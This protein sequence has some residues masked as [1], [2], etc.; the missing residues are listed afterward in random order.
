MQTYESVEKMI[1]RINARPMT[2]QQIGQVELSALKMK[3][4]CDA[5]ETLHHHEDQIVEA[6][7]NAAKDAGVPLDEEQIDLLRQ[8]SLL[9]LRHTVMAVATDDDSVLQTFAQEIQTPLMESGIPGSLVRVAMHTLNEEIFEC[10]GDVIGYQLSHMFGPFAN[11]FTTSAVVAEIEVVVANEAVSQVGHPKETSY[12]AEELVE[13]AIRY[14]RASITMLLP[15]GK[16][17]GFSLLAREHNWIERNQPDANYIL[18]LTNALLKATRSKQ[19]LEILPNYLKELTSVLDIIAYSADLQANKK[20]LLKGVKD[21]VDAHHSELLKEKDDKKKFEETVWKVY[22][23]SVAG[24]H[25]SGYSRYYETLFHLDENIRKERKDPKFWSETGM[26]IIYEAEQKLSPNSIRIARRCLYQTGFFLALSA[27]CGKS[28]MS[29]AREVSDKLAKAEKEF[30]A[31]NALNKPILKGD[32]E[33]ILWGIRFSLLPGNE[34]NS[35]EVMESFGYQIGKGDFL[36]NG[37]RSIQAFKLIEESA[38]G[39]FTLTSHC[40]FLPTIHKVQEYIERCVHINACLGSITEEVRAA[41]EKKYSG[42]V[43]KLA[44]ARLFVSQTV[45]TLLFAL[46]AGCLPNGPQTAAQAIIDTVIRVGESPLSTEAQSAIFK[47]T[48]KALETAPAESVISKEAKSLLAAVTVLQAQASIKSSII[49]Q[50]G[51]NAQLAELTKRILNI[52]AL[53]AIEEL[54]PISARELAAV[55]SEIVDG[56]FSSFSVETVVKTLPVITLDHLKGDTA[57][58]IRPIIDSVVKALCIYAKLSGTEVRIVEKACSENSAT[59]PAGPNEMVLRSVIRHCAL[60]DVPGAKVEFYRHFDGLR[61]QLKSDAIMGKW[62]SEA[63]AAVHYQFQEQFKDTNHEACLD[64]LQGSQAFFEASAE[65]AT[66]KRQVVSDAIAQ[67]DTKANQIVSSI[68]RAKEHATRDLETILEA[69]VTKL[70]PGGDHEFNRI[71]GMMKSVVEIQ[72]PYSTESMKSIIDALA[73]N[74][75]KNLK[76]DKSQTIVKNIQDLVEAFA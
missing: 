49:Q 63:T 22:E 10:F 44:D 61:E 29:V 75:A 12:T 45:E 20:A 9:S 3:K 5:A 31:S 27:D 59:P 47:L 14:L 19:I 26:A 66:M 11:F 2:L 1:D 57:N 73:Q 25:E 17:F 53:G 69:S 38:K 58:V 71:I 70:L 23:H 6:A 56:G 16:D 34:K 42:E 72:K 55:G 18:M 60:G 7:V 8:L 39:K 64:L 33:L 40:M 37:D 50:T 28:A 35:Y 74:C 4:G 43:G 36:G 52:F 68:P 76:N 48:A 32:L 62:I 51:E 67:M 30:F 54:Q 46:A 15:A 65:V 21:R 41:L 24:A 13:C